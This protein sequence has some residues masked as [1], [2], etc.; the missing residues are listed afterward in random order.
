MEI[1]KQVGELEIAKEYE[2]S[3]QIVIDLLD[4]IVLVLGDENITFEKYSK[5]LKMGF[6][7][8]NLGTIPATADQV[9]V[10]DIDRSRSHKVKIAFLIGLNDGSFPSTQKDEGF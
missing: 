3:L 2:T 10:G 5:I 1:L 6:T 8:S 7:Q 4:E 9:I